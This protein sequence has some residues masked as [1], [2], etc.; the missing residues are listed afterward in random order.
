MFGAPAYLP[1]FLITIFLC[2]CMSSTLNH[3]ALP[4]AH[5]EEAHQFFTQV[6]GLPNTRSFQVS[7]PLAT[8][9]FNHDSAVD[10]DVFENKDI[11]FEIFYTPSVTAGIYQHI[12]ITVPHK[13]DF[14]ARCQSQD[15]R[16]FF[17]Q[18]G[19]RQLLFVRDFAGHLY[20]IVE[21]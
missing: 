6:L 8:E 14:V 5:K 11:K 2:Q 16:P 20:E 19:D 1:V 21:A 17:V 4:Y 13:D 7:S 12:G 10:V 15:L 9:I 3:I 18:K